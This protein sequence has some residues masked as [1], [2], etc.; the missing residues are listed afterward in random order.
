[1][2]WLKSSDTYFLWLAAR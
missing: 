1:M 2:R